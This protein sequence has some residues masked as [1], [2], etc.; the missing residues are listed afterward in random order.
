LR[1]ADPR[2]RAARLRQRAGPE[3]AARQRQ[4]Q[5]GPPQAER[6]RVAARADPMRA[7][8]AAPAGPPLGERHRVAAQA[9]PIRG[10]AVVRRE[11][12][13]VGWLRPACLRVAAGPVWLADLPRPSVRAR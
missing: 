1:R 6:R 8:A 7:A 2:R 5:A 4:E 3:S 12:E 10:E 9:G 13:Q 11:R